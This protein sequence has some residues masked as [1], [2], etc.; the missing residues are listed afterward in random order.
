MVE[1]DEAAVQLLISH[2]QFAEAV[3][4]TVRDLD[5]PSSGLFVRVVYK[6]NSLLSTPLDV[7]NVAVLLDDAQRRCTRVT[8][9]GVSAAEAS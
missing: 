3:E 2:Q 1:C 4:P 9:T 7:G 5:H 8:R 6:L